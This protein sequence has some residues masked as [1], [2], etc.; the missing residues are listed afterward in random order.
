VAAAQEC[1]RLKP[2]Q[3]FNNGSV[4]QC[5]RTGLELLPEVPGNSVISRAGATGEVKTCRGVETF[6][7][8][9][10]PK[11]WK[12]E[13]CEISRTFGDPELRCIRFAIQRTLRQERWT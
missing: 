11:L 8:H 7:S 10:S 9:P 5:F 1:R 6:D 12:T 2:A 13:P 3:G 4:T